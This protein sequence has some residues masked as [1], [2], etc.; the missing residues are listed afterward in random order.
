MTAKP[1]Q[2]ING[3]AFAVSDVIKKAISH[4]DRLRDFKEKS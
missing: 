4:V 1:H 2:Y 3:G